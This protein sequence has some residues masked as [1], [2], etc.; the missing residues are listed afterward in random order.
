MVDIGCSHTA[1]RGIDNG[2]IFCA[3]VSES[4]FRDIEVG[5]VSGATLT[6]GQIFKVGAV[7]FAFES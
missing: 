5:Q 7:D 6:V 1:L 2:V 4:K 3:V